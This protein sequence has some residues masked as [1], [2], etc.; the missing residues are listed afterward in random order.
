VQQWLSAQSPQ[1]AGYR[2]TLDEA[3]EVGRALFEPVL[4]HNEAKLMSGS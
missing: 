3:L 1:R 2:L 4:R